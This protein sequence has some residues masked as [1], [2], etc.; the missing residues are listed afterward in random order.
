MTHAI[1]RISAGPAMRFYADIFLKYSVAVIGRKTR[2][3]GSRNETATSPDAVL[4]A[5]S[6][7]R[8]Q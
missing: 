3:P 7:A 6:P 2:V 8:F 1:W 5:A 4:S